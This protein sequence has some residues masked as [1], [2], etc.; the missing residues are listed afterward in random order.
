MLSLKEQK[1]I[2]LEY[3]CWID[4]SGNLFSF[5]DSNKSSTRIGK[6]YYRSLTGYYHSE[7]ILKYKLHE[8]NRD[9]KIV[10]VEF[11]KGENLL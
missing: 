4:Y 11:L 3:N 7:S 6:I 9:F 1:I 8:G 2:C 10:L 5:N